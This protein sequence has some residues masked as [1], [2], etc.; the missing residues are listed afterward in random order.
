MAALFKVVAHP[1]R[2]AILEI[3]RQEEEC[4]CHIEAA[5]GLRQAYISQQLTVLRQSGLVTDR[6]DGWNVFYQVARPEVYAIVDA[7]RTMLPEHGQRRPRAFPAMPKAG[8]CPCPKCQV[9]A[10]A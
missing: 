1:V 8:T 10:A 9:E 2:L 7:A 5:L 3:L 4:V 6:R